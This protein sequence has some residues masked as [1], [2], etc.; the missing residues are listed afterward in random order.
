MTSYNTKRERR[1]DVS[2]LRL[3]VMRVLYLRHKAVLGV[4]RFGGVLGLINTQRLAQQHT[5]RR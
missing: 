4:D 3:Y 5:R 1:D 2:T